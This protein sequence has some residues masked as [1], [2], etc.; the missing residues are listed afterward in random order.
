MVPVPA[1]QLYVPR[2][3]RMEAD[4]DRAGVAA[5]LAADGREPDGL[6]AP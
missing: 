1:P 5:G 6:V 4:E 3:N 2:F